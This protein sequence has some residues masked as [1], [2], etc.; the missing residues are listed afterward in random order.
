MRRMDREGIPRW[1]MQR[2]FNERAAKSPINPNGWRVPDT[3]CEGA[4]LLN[5]AVGTTRRQII[6]R[7]HETPAG[8]EFDL[9]RARSYLVD[10]RQCPAPR[11]P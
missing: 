2:R 4:A 5:L 11:L 9:R 8:R 1:E 3:V 10:A 7:N 6:L